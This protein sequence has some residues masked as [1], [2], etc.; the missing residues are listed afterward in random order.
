[1]HRTSSVR[2]GHDPD[3]PLH[4]QQPVVV[5]VAGQPG[6]AKTRIADL[7]Q[8]AL[9]RRGDS[10][11]RRCPAWWQAAVEA[12]VRAMGVDAVVESAPADPDDFRAV[13]RADRA[14][15]HRIE[16]VALATAEALNQIG[17]VD[18]FLTEAAAG[19]GRYVAGDH[20][21]RCAKAMLTTLAVIEAESLADGIAVMRRNGTVLYADEL[22][23]E[24]NR[25]RRPG[26]DQV[27]RA[28]RTRPWT[29][30]ETAVFRCEP[31]GEDRR[32]AVQ[33]DSERAA[34]WSEPVRRTAQPTA[35]GEAAQVLALPG[36]LGSVVGQVTG[37]RGGSQDGPGPCGVAHQVPCGAHALSERLHRVVAAR[38]CLR[39]GTAQ[40]RA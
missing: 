5:V 35:L 34:A 1:M 14:S 12:H 2:V 18:R 17:I 39:S 11:L 15:G 8:A 38:R 25:R 19:G 7:V 33:R 4:E 22:N 40:W 28:E 13:S 20:H 21:G 6:A 3:K 27:V 37:A 32:L 10:A 9:N 24:G 16:V 31:A 29:A 26:T 30:P 36:M 23:R